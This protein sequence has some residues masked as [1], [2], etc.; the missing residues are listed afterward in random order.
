MKE[1]GGFTM[2]KFVKVTLIL[3]ILVAG[4]AFGL[5]SNNDSQHNYSL[6]FENSGQTEWY[7][8]VEVKANKDDLGKT[9]GFKNSGL[10]ETIE[11]RRF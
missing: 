7:E 6:D 9:L 2:K 1:N 5:S 8:I 3:V 11:F 10:P 4:L